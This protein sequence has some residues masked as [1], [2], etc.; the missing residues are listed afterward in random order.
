METTHAFRGLEEKSFL[1]GKKSA[2]FWLRGK[3]RKKVEKKISETPE[4]KGGDIKRTKKK[5]RNNDEVGTWKGIELENE[6]SG[7]D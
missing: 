3:K 7:T 4:E 5:K 1:I 2:I 6:L